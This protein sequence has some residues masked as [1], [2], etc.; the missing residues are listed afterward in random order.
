MRH[1][2]IANATKEYI[3][4]R[5]QMLGFDSLDLFLIKMVSGSSDKST[6]GHY[7]NK[8][9]LGME[10]PDGPVIPL[11]DSELISMIQKGL[12]EDQSAQPIFTLFV[13][14]WLRRNFLVR[15]TLKDYGI[16]LGPNDSDPV[17]IP[18]DIVLYKGTQPIA[19]I[20]CR[21]HVNKVSLGAK[22][23]YYCKAARSAYGQIPYFIIANTP[24]PI[25][26][27]WYKKLMALDVNFIVIESW[28]DLSQ[29]SV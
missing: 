18:F 16:I 20:D 1:L 26:G 29:I 28:N 8:R 27:E 23:Y 24:F 4:F 12:I 25:T 13:G 22:E 11:V 3:L 9:F 6:I 21:Y 2:K 5:Q 17:H 7:L 10:A 14:R 15:M 19:F